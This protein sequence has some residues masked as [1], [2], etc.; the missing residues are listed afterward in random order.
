MVKLP[1]KKKVLSA[2]VATALTCG[3]ALTGPAHAIK[4]SNNGMGQVLLAPLYQAD[5]GQSTLITLVNT[6]TTHAAKVKAVFRS[7][8]HCIEVLDFI[9]YL[10]PGDVWRGEVYNK[11]GQAY[12]RSNDDSIRNLPNDDS[13]ASIQPVDFLL[14]DQGLEKGSDATTSDD[15][16]NEMGIIEFIGHYT[17]TGTI[18][19]GV[20]ENVTIKQGMSKFDLARIIDMSVEQI[21]AQN[22]VRCPSAG[23]VNQR[24]VANTTCP[25]RINDI[26]NFKLRG[27]IEVV[28]PDG[29]MAY[30]MTA[31]TSTPSTPFT[32]GTYLIANPNLEIDVSRETSLGFNWDLTS[33]GVPGLARDNIDEIELALATSAISGSY[34]NGFTYEGDSSQVRYTGIQIS[35]PTKYRHRADVCETGAAIDPNKGQ[36]YPPFTLNG[37]VQYQMVSFDN[38]ENSQRVGSSVSGGAVAIQTVTDCANMLLGQSND[39]F[40]YDSGFYQFYLNARYP[41]AAATCNY[42]GVPAIAQTYKYTANSAGNTSQQMLIPASSNNWKDCDCN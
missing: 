2:A 3:M 29:R 4:V 39:L 32:Q 5:V 20:G 28:T 22:S 41:N 9:L 10:S 26:N 16:I 21:T 6:S 23:A 37:D 38:Q 31:L 11:N 8:K 17:A 19:P 36:Y 30:Q 34:E 18:V 42:A 12:I 27:N 35:F 33:L 13:F 7:K 14:F 1:F 15:D 40:N 24:G 25:V